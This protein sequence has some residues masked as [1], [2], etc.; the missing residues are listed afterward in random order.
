MR[1]VV[2]ALSVAAFFAA[3]MHADPRRVDPKTYLDHVKFWRPKISK[4]VATAAAVSKPRQTT[5]PHDSAKP[6][7][8]LRAIKRRSSSASK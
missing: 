2:V 3:S 7:W 8:N 5:L 4:G 6:A 1:R